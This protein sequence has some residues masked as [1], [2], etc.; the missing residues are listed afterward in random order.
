MRCLGVLSGCRTANAATGS[1]VTI[2]RARAM[3]SA[4]PPGRRWPARRRRGTPRRAPGEAGRRG[5]PRSVSPPGRAPGLWPSASVAV[6]VAAARLH[7]PQQRH[8]GGGGF[9]PLRVRRRRRA[10]PPRGAGGQARPRG[11]AAAGW[12]RERP[13]GTAAGPRSTTTSGA[14]AHPPRARRGS[15]AA[16]PNC[17]PRVSALP[18]A[19]AGGQAPRRRPSASSATASRLL[20]VDRVVGGAVSDTPMSCAHHQRGGAGASCHPGDDG[21]RAGL[22]RRSRR[23]MR[24]PVGP[25]VG[26]GRVGERQGQLRLDWM[27]T[28]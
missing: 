27:S 15:L 8:H 4:R 14:V 3:P 10:G 1:S 18:S 21:V 19:M 22:R 11:R 25:P 28:G 23:A 13:G 12:E 6:Q 7:Q 20:K 5:R 2:S 9:A 16:S 26:G 24:H 17:P